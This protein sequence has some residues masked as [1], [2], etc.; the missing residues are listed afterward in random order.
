[1]PD[2]SNGRLDGRYIS[3]IGVSVAVERLLR[4][5]YQV[6]LP[7]I[8]D[9]YD[10]LAFCGRRYWRIQVKATA[11]DT[12][13]RYRIR[14]GQQENLLHARPGRRLHSGAHHDWGRDVRSVRVCQ[15]A[16]VDQLFGPSPVLGLRR[17]KEAQA[18]QQ[19]TI[20]T[21]A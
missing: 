11:C 4:D 1:M 2:P 15:G 6:A 3:E 9:G 20:R 17:H 7:I 5:G 14:I 19:L 18:A 21:T 12:K 8:D 13:N 16:A 10:L